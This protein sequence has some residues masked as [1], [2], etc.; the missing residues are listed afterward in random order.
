MRADI[1]FIFDLDET[2]VHTDMRWVYGLFRRAF[3]EI[4]KRPTKEQVRR[5][6]NGK[7]T[8]GVFRELG[9]EPMEYWRVH[10]KYDT[11]EARL[12]HT[13]MH[14]DA[15]VL[16]QRLH[17]RYPLAVMTGAPQYIVEAEVAPVRCYFKATTVANLDTGIKAKPAPDGLIACMDEL[18]ASPEYTW[19][20]GN[21]CEDVECAHNARVHSA[22][23]ERNGCPP[24]ELA[25]DITLRSLRRLE[26]RVL[27]YYTSR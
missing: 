17:R 18:N 24:P 19:Y 5:I 10:R 16:L 2:L 13:W 20:V 23:V 14:P 27:A 1:A 4:G 22:L 21:A 6:W 15:F 26:Q 7:D 8:T 9:I 3:K 12:K 11:A 25:P